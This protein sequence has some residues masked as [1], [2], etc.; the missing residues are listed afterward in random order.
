M[1]WLFYPSRECAT[2]S[3]TVGEDI[4]QQNICLP[5]PRIENDGDT[6]ACIRLIWVARNWQWCHQRSASWSENRPPQTE[7]LAR[8]F[9]IQSRSW[10][11]WCRQIGTRPPW[12]EIS[13]NRSI[14]W[15]RFPRRPDSSPQLYSWRWNRQSCPPPPLV[16]PTHWGEPGSPWKHGACDCNTTID[17][18]RRHRANLRCATHRAPITWLLPSSTIPPK[19]KGFW[20]HVWILGFFLHGVFF[21]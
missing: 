21:M 10:R 11:M 20:R 5:R 4:H 6:F 18:C 8:D 9:S 7:C 1:S 3:T 19:A 15:P 2:Y 17:D 14:L 16:R 13:W 12:W